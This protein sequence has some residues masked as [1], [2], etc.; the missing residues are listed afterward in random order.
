MKLYRKIIHPCVNKDKQHDFPND[1][2]REYKGRWFSEESRSKL[3]DEIYQ[4]YAKENEKKISFFRRFPLA[5]REQYIEVSFVTNMDSKI[6][7]LEEK[8]I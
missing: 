7:D 2:L 1:I 4:S 5:W 8:I 3:Y 6:E